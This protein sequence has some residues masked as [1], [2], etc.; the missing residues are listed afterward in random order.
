MCAGRKKLRGP[1]PP[2]MVCVRGPLQF[3]F[4]GSPPLVQGVHEEKEKGRSG[5][6]GG[7]SLGQGG[8]IIFLGVPPLDGECP[9]G[10]GKFCHGSPPMLHGMREGE[11][12]P[13]LAGGPG[14]CYFVP[15]RE[16][17]PSGKGGAEKSL[18]GVTPGEI[19]VP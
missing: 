13:D 19:G 6:P 8:M 1:P 18:R 2:G 3:I 9:G 7:R 12:G 11:A 14:R 4:Q 17:V 10:A 16:M 5:G 15:G